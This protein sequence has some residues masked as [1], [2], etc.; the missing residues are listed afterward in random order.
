MD[1]LRPM[2]Q[3]WDLHPF[4]IYDWSHVVW[5]VSKKHPSLYPL[6]TYS[7]RGVEDCDCAFKDQQIGP[8]GRQRS[9][10]VRVR[11]IADR[12]CCIIC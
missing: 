7:I 9:S 2:T 8:V 1:S 4:W 5:V 12:L 10:S 11:P 6:V 3:L